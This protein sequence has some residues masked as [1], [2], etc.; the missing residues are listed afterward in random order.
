MCVE[1]TVDYW[2]K[3]YEEMEPDVIACAHCTIGAHILE[4]LRSQEISHIFS[5]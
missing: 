2:E 3:G 1:W 4:Q 5:I